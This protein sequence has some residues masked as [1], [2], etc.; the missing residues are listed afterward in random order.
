MRSRLGMQKNSSKPTSISS[1][2]RACFFQFWKYR[3][4]FW[5]FRQLLQSDCQNCN[6]GTSKPGPISIDFVNYSNLRLQW[7]AIFDK[8]AKTNHYL[9]TRLHPIANLTVLGTPISSIIAIRSKPRKQR[10]CIFFIFRKYCIFCNYCNSRF[11][12]L[13]QLLQSGCRNC[14]TDWN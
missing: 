2:F 4:R 1:I 13:S 3:L 14:E 10:N 8:T 12:A 5:A 7:I 11:E 6:S 9:Q